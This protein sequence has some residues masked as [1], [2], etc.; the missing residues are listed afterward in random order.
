MTDDDDAGRGP[1]ISYNSAPPPAVTP[2]PS[3]PALPCSSGAWLGSRKRIITKDREFIEAHTEYLKARTTQSNAMTELIESRVT[4]AL[5]MAKLSALPEIAQH[6]YDRGR[7][8]RQSEAIQ[9]THAARVASL[10]HE[11]AEI[12]AQVD[13]LR[14]KQRLADLEP[15]PPAPPEPAPAPPPAPPGL[16]PSDVEDVLSALPE[17]APETLKTISRLLVGLLKE[18]GG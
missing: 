7:A 1:L 12:N 14:A 13:L 3:M 18:K 15:K 16:S 4:A 8:L 11:R 10:E 6:E 5:T 9:W 17:I 2:T